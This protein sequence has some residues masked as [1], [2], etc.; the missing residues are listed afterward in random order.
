MLKGK[1]PGLKFKNLHY[2][3]LVLTL[4]KSFE[5]SRPSFPHLS[6]EGVTLEQSHKV[7]DTIDVLA[8]N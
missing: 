3:T 7:L 5:V 1:R 2:L 6:H 8:F 4:S